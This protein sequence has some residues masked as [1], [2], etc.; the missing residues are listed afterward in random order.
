MISLIDKV[1]NYCSS[2]YHLN[3]LNIS[4]Q[5]V[6]VVTAACVGAAENGV[7]QYTSQRPSAKMAQH[8]LVLSSIWIEFQTNLGVEFRSIH[9]QYT[10]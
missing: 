8:N 7:Y 4:P 2:I 9:Y 10:L 3:N 6:V 5:D 1:L